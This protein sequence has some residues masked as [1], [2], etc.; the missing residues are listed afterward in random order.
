MGPDQKWGASWRS[1]VRI[2]CYLPGR[3]GIVA[4]SSGQP[5]ALSRG[6]IALPT[7][8][9]VEVDSLVKH[10]ILLMVEYGMVIHYVLGHTVVQILGLLYAYDSLLV[11]QFP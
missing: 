3:T 2:R 6:G 1:Y 11:S 8:S 7:L 5:A 4:L 10:L 9:N